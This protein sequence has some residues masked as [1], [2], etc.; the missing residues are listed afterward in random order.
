MRKL[1]VVVCLT[2][3]AAGAAA[4]QSREKDWEKCLGS[5]PTAR[6]DGCQAVIAAKPKKDRL[7]TAYLN[8]GIAASQLLK[9]DIAITSLTQALSLD[10]NN[11][12][13][14]FYR[15]QAYFSGHHFQDALADYN[16]YIQLQPN[17]SRGYFS[18]A[19]VYGNLAEFDKGIADIDQG[20]S[21]EPLAA[22]P[23]CLRANFYAAKEDWD[24]AFADHNL[25]LIRMPGN[26]ALYVNRG[27][28]YQRNRQ[29][30]KAITD[31]DEALR[32]APDFI[33][34]LVFRATAHREMGRADLSIA[35]Y[36][37]YI[38]LNPKDPRAFYGRGLGKFL[39]GDYAGAGADY[40]H[41]LELAPPSNDSFPYAALWARLAAE[42]QGQDDAESLAHQAA[43]LDLT[44]WPGPILKFYLGQIPAEQMRA[45]TADPDVEKA[46]GRVCEANFF[47]GERA[48]WRGDTAAAVRLLLEARDGCPRSFYEFEAAVTELDRLAKK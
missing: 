7:L 44:K 41:F 26:P 34:A 17:D 13:A 36:D 12:G 46:R 42:R 3:G 43:K 48:R 11:A 21:L 28:A 2:L 39:Q 10:P 25:C 14:Y 29:F 9:S 33:E 19:N 6:L 16:K 45:A 5:D 40:G 22:Y 1:V 15:G 27:L 24:R 20:L 30:E 38:G 4:G 35:D 31:F 18:R 47:E 8:R 37:R 23:I 32:V